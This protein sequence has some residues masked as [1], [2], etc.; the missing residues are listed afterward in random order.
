M[1][2]RLNIGCGHVQ[3]EGWV[4]IDASHRARFARRFHWLDRVLVCLGVLPGTEFGP[5]VRNDDVRRRLRFADATVDAIYCGEMLEHLTESQGSHFLAE[6][7]RILAPGGVLRVRVPDNYRYWRNYLEQYERVRR[8]PRQWW[9][10]EH[11]R[12][13]RHFFDYI[14]VRRPWLGSMGHFHKF[15]YDEVSLVLA[16]EAA[17]F[18]DV[19]RHRMHDS[20][21]EGVEHVEVRED[22]IVEGVKPADGATARVPGPQRLAA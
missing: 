12:W 17:G 15:M 18:T 6:C 2:T 5:H 22:L 14:C 7:R 10:D 1:T 8:M 13:T 3:P 19:S 9:T 4:H 11:A 21:I 20:R 16:F